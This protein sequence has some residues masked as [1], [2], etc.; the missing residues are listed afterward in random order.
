MAVTDPGTDD[1]PP[2]EADDD[3]PEGPVETVLEVVDELTTPA[4][5]AGAVALDT[6]LSRFDDAVDAQFDRLRGHPAVD[7]LMYSVTELAD[8][9]LLWH[10]L[11]ATRGLG[12]ERDAAAAVRLSTVLAVESTLVNAGLKSL[13]RRQRPIP[14]FERPHHLRIPVTTSFPSGHAS[15]AMCAATLLADGR[16]RST[17]VGWFA[18]GGLVAASRVHVKIHHASDVLGGVAVGVV[19]GQVARRLWRQR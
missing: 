4:P 5:T 15:A 11:G 9:S 6:R 12:S 13:F 17:R 3:G 14:E 16:V 19:V 1:I 7:R 8:F 2:G 18:L 10:L